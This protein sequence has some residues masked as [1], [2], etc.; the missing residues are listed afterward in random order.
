[1]CLSSLSSESVP[2]ART[3]YHAAARTPQ[4]EASLESV[5]VATEMP[6]LYLRPESVMSASCF[7][8]ARGA[9]GAVQGRCWFEPLVLCLSSLSRRLLRL[10]SL[11]SF[12]LPDALFCL[13]CLACLSCRLSFAGFFCCTFSLF[14]LGFGKPFAHFL[15][16]STPC[17]LLHPQ[18]PFPR[19]C[20]CL[21][22]RLFLLRSNLAVHSLQRRLK[23]LELGLL[24][25]QLAL[26]DSPTGKSMKTFCFP[27][28]LLLAR[29]LHL[30][31]GGR[32]QVCLQ[33]IPVHLLAY[34][35]LILVL[36]SLQVCRK[37]SNHSTEFEG[38][39]VKSRFQQSQRPKAFLSC[40]IFLLLFRPLFSRSVSLCFCGLRLALL[41]F[42]LCS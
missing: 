34:I 31:V 33:A 25:M 27:C 23:A 12:C 6:S 37:C 22:C 17:F 1:M 5:T 13:A 35:L 8:R 16:H 28:L 36:E 4:S 40:I 7:C 29:F 38:F 39:T 10:A 42:L 26:L 32:S 19:L 14:L 11:R 21:V 9:R 3:G 15:L 18:Y 24:L 2:A 41:R 20:Q 30:A